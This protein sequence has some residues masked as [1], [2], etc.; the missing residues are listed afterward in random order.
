M[1]KLLHI[2]QGNGAVFLE[3]VDFLLSVV[4]AGG[5]YTSD[6]YVIA[7]V[8]N[9]DLSNGT[10]VDIISWALS[11][12]TGDALLSDAV[13]TAAPVLDDWQFNRLKLEGDKSNFFLI[14]AHV[15]SATPEPTT[16]LFVF[17]GIALIKKRR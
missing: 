12:S 1:A 16:I 15:T 4:N 9:N 11:D 17:L 2:V 7:S 10:L 5:P 8:D 13:P 14:N 6:D 3:N